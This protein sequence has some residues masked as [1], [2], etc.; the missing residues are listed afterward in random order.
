MK[1]M[2]RPMPIAIAFLSSRGMASMTFS[3][4]PMSTSA[5]TSAPSRTTMPIASGKPSPSPATSVK[6]TTAFNP[7]P[8][9]IAYARFVTSPIAIDIP[10]ATTHVD[11][12]TPSNGRPMSSR[13]LMPAKLKIAGLTKMMYDMTMKVVTPAIVS[14][15]NVVPFSLKR[16]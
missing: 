13:P 15:A 7:R 6:A 16:K 5:V 4:I 12:R 8:G 11:A 9:A 3:R 14:R 1:A 10:P 2:K